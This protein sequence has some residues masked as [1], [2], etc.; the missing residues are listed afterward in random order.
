M[1]F[2]AILVDESYNMSRKEQMELFL[3]FV[4][5]KGEAVERFVGL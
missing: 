2:F 5:R 3:R 4:N 1:I